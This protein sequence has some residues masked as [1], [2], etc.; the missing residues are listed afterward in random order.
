M[1]HLALT[2]LG[3]LLLAIACGCASLGKQTKVDETIRGGQTVTTSEYDDEE[4]NYAGD[5]AP[6]DREDAAETMHSLQPQIQ[7]CTGKYR[8]SGTTTFIIS[9]TA[10][11][12]VRAVRSEGGFAGTAQAECIAKVIHSAP[13]PPCAPTTFPFPLTINVR[14]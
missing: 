3:S 11:G 7:H 10:G 2:W 1:R 9:V 5:L 14:R 8:E 6:L 13:F 4:K 12:R